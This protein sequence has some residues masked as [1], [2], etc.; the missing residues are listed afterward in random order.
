NNPY[1][2]VVFDIPDGL[3]YLGNAGDLTY[4]L[5]AAEWTAS[6][7]TFDA[8]A[9]TLTAQ[10]DL[11]IPFNLVQSQF[12]LKLTLDCDVPNVNGQASVGMQLFYAMDDDCNGDPYKL[13]LSCKQY[14]LTYLHCPGA[15][16]EGL[17]FQTFSM[18]RT[19]FGSP[20]NDED[21]LADGSGSLDLTKVK[22]NRVMVGD[23]FS[24]VFT[25]EVITSGTYPSWS[26]G[27]AK[28]QLP[29]GNSLTALYATISVYDESTSSTLVCSD[30]PL[31]SVVN[32]DVMTM[33]IDWSPA[34]LNSAGCTDFNTFILE[35]GD[36]IT[37]T[38]YYRV[39]GNIGGTVEQV[40]ATNDF[41]V[42]PS[43]NGTAFQCDDWAGNITM[44][45]YYWFVDKSDWIN[46]RACETTVSQSYYLS[47]GDCC[48]NYNGGNL[49]PAEYRNWGHVKQVRVE[50]PD[51]YAYVSASISQVRTA[52]TNGSVTENVSSISP[53]STLGND[54]YFDLEAQHDGYGG[55][56]NVSDDGFMGTVSIVLDP[57]CNTNTSG[58][59]KVNWYYTFE[60]APILNGG[61]TTAEYDYGSPDRL[62][63]RPAKYDISSP[64]PTQDVGTRSVTWDVDVKNNQ[65]TPSPNTFLYPTAPNGNIT[66]TQV[67]DVDGDS[68]IPL[69]SDFYRLGD[70]AK[71]ENRN[72]QI[73]GTYTACDLDQLDLYVGYDCDGYPADFA[74]HTCGNSSGSLYLNPY[75]A[76]MQVRIEGTTF[77]AESCDPFVQ[78]EVEIA[79]V[80]LGHIDDIAVDVSVPSSGSL[81]WDAGSTEVL[82][83][84]S[85]EYSTITDPVINSFEYR[86]TAADMDATIDAN[87]L[88]GVTDVSSNRMKLRFNIAMQSNFRPG[89]FITVAISSKEMCGAGLPT[90]YLAY[91][92]SQ[93][94][95]K[96]EGIGLDDLADTRG[97]SWADY[98]GDGFVDLFMPS[99][100]NGQGNFLYKND[101]DGTFTKVTSGALV[102]ETGVAT[103]STWADYDND[104]DLD[105]F[106][107]QNIGDF[108]LLFRNNGDGTFVKI[109]NDP[110]VSDNGY[111]HGAAWGDYDNDGFVDLFVADLFSSRFN[112]LYRNNGDGTFTDMSTSE[113]AQE[114][115]SSISGVWG[116]YDNDGD[117]DL[118][119]SNRGENDTNSLYENKGGGRFDKVST[120]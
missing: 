34:T 67:Y 17:S 56:L 70:M 92:P 88:E 24:T 62:K 75:P 47:I 85:G 54:Y 18:Q 96:T 77:P 14:P 60:E 90:I 91:D 94:F 21:G 59:K 20:D 10:Y 19:S 31:S 117:L 63:Y 23:T 25:G 71:K 97:L 115:S 30:V 64:L 2:E 6:S 36:D 98:D 16:T 11:P 102:A 53:S 57:V 81:L 15:C 68:I 80:K 116:D 42:S 41:Y 112:Q 104:G 101:G 82:Y 32:S 22:A 72:L 78:I 40:Q 119:V 95:G 120:G 8:G 87:G 105:V 61:G 38:V 43:A 5:G 44:I 76:E 51:D 28:S 50:I 100:T 52:N 93:V 83:P 79:S 55:T 99:Y 103:G 110:I 89:E 73:T 108:N 66:V 35:D 48:S 106:I 7:I 118:F 109:E 46:V 111:S 114:A 4:K 29:Y 113:I 45:G 12:D 84:L 1:F 27:Y 107:T 3:E 13:P 65:N 33:D 74:S 86:L 58:T 39:T 26:Y 9:K 37:L 49:F 69:T